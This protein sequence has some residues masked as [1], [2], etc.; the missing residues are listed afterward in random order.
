MKLLIEAKANINAENVRAA[1]AP[2]VRAADAGGGWRCGCVRRAHRLAAACA[3]A[4]WCGARARLWSQ[5]DKKTPLHYA[6]L[7]TEMGH[8]EA[9]KVLID[10]CLLYTSPSPRD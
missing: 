8:V 9:M 10:A 6:H 3:R 5:N 4:E 1:H 7:A 2:P